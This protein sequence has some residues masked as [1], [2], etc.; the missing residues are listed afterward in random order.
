MSACIVSIRATVRSVL[1]R[2]DD[3]WDAA[4][5]DAID[6]V[7]S[8]LGTRSGDI[9]AF[10]RLIA[11]SRAIDLLRSVTTRSKVDQLDDLSHIPDEHE[12]L[13]LIDLTPEQ[14]TIARMLAKGE[15]ERS[16]MET[17]GISRRKLKT[18]MAAIAELYKNHEN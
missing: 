15:S 12:S 4:E 9:A 1:I 5:S 7:W 6:Q 14:Q 3:L 11:R 18:A 13:E 2:R 16:V 17:L 10:V 8:K